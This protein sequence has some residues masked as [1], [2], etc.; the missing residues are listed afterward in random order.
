MEN[1]NIQNEEVS[2]ENINPKQQI[3]TPTAIIVAGFLIMV[4]IL[5]TKSGV[6]ENKPKTLSEQ[7]GVSKA[8][9]EACINNVDTKKVK[10]DIDASVNKAMS[11]YALQ[12]RG[13][14][15]SV[16]IGLN[17]VKTDIR[18]AESYDVVKKVIDDAMIGKVERPYVG[19]I[20]LSEPTDHIN[21]SKDAKVTIIEYSD[22]ECPFCKQFH[23]ILE[24]IVKENNGNV[25]W[26]YRN[27]PL[28]QHS[29]EK[30]LAANCVAEI[31]GGD[32]FWKYSD[33]LFGLLKTANDSV[34][35]QL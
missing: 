12:D 28:H 30:L 3:S 32:A 26:I 31:K 2:K 20:E 5:M 34:S 9:M 21:G 27:Y 24:R 33:L 7:V 23:P 35:D 16:V 11:N 8:K 25:A 6:I 13:T 18:G 10:S 17:G 4:G 1:N 19:N 29:F 22:F 15:Y 14:P